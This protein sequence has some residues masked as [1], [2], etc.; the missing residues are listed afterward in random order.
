MLDRILEPEIMDSAEE[1]RD[2]DAMDHSAVNAAF[3]SDF[4]AVWNKRSPILDVGAGT[5]QIPIEFCRQ[6]FLGKIQAIDL[7]DHMLQLAFANVN[8]SPYAD[9]IDI[10]KVNARH[11]PFADSSFGAIMSN[12]IM[13]HIPEPRHVFA[14]M[15]RVAMPGATMFVRDLLRP[16][17]MAT[18]D[19]L[20]GLYAAGANIHQRQLFAQS[21]H[22]A[23]TLDEARSLVGEIGFDE[24]TV[25][26]TSDRHW[27]W[28]AHKPSTL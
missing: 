8:R 9:R 2:Y 11:T 16:A 27:T 6:S 18:L 23:L 3:I 21:L 4:L 22:A 13:H 19:K 24:A 25:Q 17:D 12:S 14:E 20:V 15:V 28:S 5:A 7:A 26:Q 10:Q 1:A